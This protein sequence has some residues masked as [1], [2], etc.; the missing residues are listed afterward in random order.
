M[1]LTLPPREVMMIFLHDENSI[2]KT[3]EL[4]T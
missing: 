1:Q 2:T 3:P 4:P